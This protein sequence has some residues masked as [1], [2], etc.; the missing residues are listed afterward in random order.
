MKDKLIL[1]PLNHTWFF[2]IDGTLVKHNGYKIDGIDT[3]LPGVKEFFDK[4]PSDDMVVLVTSRKSET[5]ELTEAFLNK[6]GI[7]FNT[8]LYDLPYGERIIVNDN[9]PSGLSVS[10]A[11]SLNRDQGLQYKKIE[12]DPSL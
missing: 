11:V 5:K 4:I 2:D 3:L 9:K 10:V 1:S 12:I 8:I 7:R 6:N